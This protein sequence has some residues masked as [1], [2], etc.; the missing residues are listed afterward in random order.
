MACDPNNSGPEFV[1]DPALGTEPCAVDSAT[2]T[3]PCEVTACCNYYSLI[4]EG[5]GLS[6]IYSAGGPF[7]IVEDMEPCAGICTPLGELLPL[8]PSPGGIAGG[9]PVLDPGPLSDIIC[10]PN[11]PPG[12]YRAAARVEL[13]AATPATRIVVLYLP[14]CEDTT[15]R[16]LVMECGTPCP[17]CEGGEPLCPSDNLACSNYLF[18]ENTGCS[19][20]FQ[21]L[22]QAGCDSSGANVIPWIQNVQLDLQRISGRSLVT[23]NGS[24]L[25]N[26]VDIP[27]QSQTCVG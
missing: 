18:V 17:C 20:G 12:T 8:P 14:D 3:T 25:V 21:I 23:C 7:S 1:I 6:F 24:D 9:R 10:M 11:L 16:Y 15:T 5:R 13:F 22:A 26:W 19:P 27:T 2:S 4:D